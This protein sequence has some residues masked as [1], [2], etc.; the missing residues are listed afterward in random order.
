MLLGK[1]LLEKE[2]RK[3]ELSPSKFFKSEELLGVVKELSQ[4][5]VEDLL[6]AIGYGKVSAHQVANKLAPDKVHIEPGPKKS[7]FKRAKPA[8]SSGGMKINGM[9]NMMIHLSQCCNPVP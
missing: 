8:S 5:T 6:A 4:N 7:F 3:Y 1:E 9:D 2:L